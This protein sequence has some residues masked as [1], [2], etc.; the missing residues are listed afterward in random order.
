MK[1]KLFL[2]RLNKQGKISNEEADKAI[3]SLPE[4]HE[5]PDVWVN[6]FEENFLTRDRAACR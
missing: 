3:N 2:Q 1:T 5:L 4:D 6:L